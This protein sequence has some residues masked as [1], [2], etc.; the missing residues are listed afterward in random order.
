MTYEHD[1]SMELVE[2]VASLEEGFLLRHIWNRITTADLSKHTFE[3]T[4]AALA[5]TV[6]GISSPE[7]IEALRRDRQMGRAHMMKI[8]E[9]HPDA[10]ER[11]EA[12][13]HLAWLEDEYV[14]MLSDR[15][16]EIKHDS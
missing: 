7:D 2:A 15:M 16:K 4:R 1:E 5:K 12:K 3:N 11:D 6:A 9:R 14:K 13:R 8:I 10:A